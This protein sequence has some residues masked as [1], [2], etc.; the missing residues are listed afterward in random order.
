MHLFFSFSNKQINLFN[1]LEQYVHKVHGDSGLVL[2]PRQV[3][4][5]NPSLSRWHGVTRCY[6]NLS[7][8]IKTQK[9]ILEFKL[10][11]GKINWP[12]PVSF[13][14][15]ILKCVILPPLI[16]RM[17]MRVRHV[18]SHLYF[19]VVL[20]IKVCTT[21]AQPLWPTSVAA[22]I[23]GLCQHCLASMAD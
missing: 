6:W 16:L 5:T 9:H 15:F 4:W 18:S 1:F 2:M 23:K 17:R 20:E 10:Q 13:L 14:Y 19:Y 7:H 3:N 8:L 22:A 12:T 11:V 21:T